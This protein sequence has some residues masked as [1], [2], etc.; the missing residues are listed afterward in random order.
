MPKL[1]SI[2][3]I[4]GMMLLVSTGYAKLPE[5][6]QL[7]ISGGIGSNTCEEGGLGG[8]GWPGTAIRLGDN[9]FGKKKGATLSTPGII[10]LR[11]NNCNMEHVYAT[12]NGNA[13][14]DDS[15]LFQIG[16]SAAG[17]AIKLT[18]QSWSGVAGQQ[19]KP[20][21]ERTYQDRAIFGEVRMDFKPELIQT[22]DE[23]SS[24]DLTTAI[25]V[26]FRYD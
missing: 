15:T 20:G 24:G 23:I 17:V 5:S 8:G 1:N 16:G 3:I 26:T 7:V 13:D 22:R 9:V 2:F 6:T 18:D 21:V 4:V 11:V 14:P 19:I 12:W 25:T 10:Q